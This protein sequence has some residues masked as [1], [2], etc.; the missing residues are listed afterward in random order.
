MHEMSGLDNKVLNTIVDSSLKGLLY[1][2]DLLTIS[3]KNVIDYDLCSEGS[4]DGPVRI[5]LCNGPLNSADIICTAFV[6]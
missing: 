1:I 6:K 3:C 2:V 4:S 5:S